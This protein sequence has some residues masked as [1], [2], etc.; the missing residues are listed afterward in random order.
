MANDHNISEESPQ[1]T[2]RDFIHISACAF[3][4][5]GAGAAI[6]PFIDSMN[7]ADDVL[8]SSTVDVD[9]SKLNPGDSLTAMWRGKP[10]FIKRRTEEEV[11]AVRAIPLKDLKDP[12]TDQSRV[13]RPDWLVVIGVC[14]H[15]G[16]I[17][18]LRK[19]LMAGN[20]GWLC[21]CHGS[22]Y[23]G[24][25]RIISGPAPANLAVPAYTFINDNKVIRIGEKA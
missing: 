21:A 3:A 8:A 12:Q 15:L 19:N 10:I 23:D 17:P 9:V 13:E 1:T 22:R 5:V 11:K 25:G 6:V 14:T 2:R 20:D 4:A 16:C 18:T 24:S 7:P